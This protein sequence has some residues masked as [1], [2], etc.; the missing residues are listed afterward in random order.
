ME[1]D[2]RQLLNARIAELLHAALVTIR[3]ATW[4]TVPGDTDRR[5][6]V[7]DLADLLHNLPK[8]VVGHDEH[9]IDSA[10]QLREA[11]LQHV[12]RFYPTIHPTQHRYIYLLD[13]DA[14]AFLSQFRDHNWAA[15]VVATP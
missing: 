8:Y 3:A 11:V 7:N 9:A 1:I 14:E 10:E 2:E 15:P 4:P 13:L 5:D 12:K 6:E